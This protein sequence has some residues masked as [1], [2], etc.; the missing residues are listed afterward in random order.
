VTGVERGDFW[1]CASGYRTETS[2]PCCV[3]LVAA[4]LLFPSIPPSVFI[5]NGARHFIV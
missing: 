3:L 5:S 2:A 4:N 1:V